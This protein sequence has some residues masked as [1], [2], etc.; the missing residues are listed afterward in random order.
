[1]RFVFVINIAV[2]LL[3]G[4]V[5]VV[6]ANPWYADKIPNGRNVPHPGPQG[7]DRKSVV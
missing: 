4:A 5:S 3:F 6:N 7:G 2:T 1:M